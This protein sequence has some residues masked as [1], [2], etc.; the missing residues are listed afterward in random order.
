MQEE[1]SMEDMQIP[2]WTFLRYYI[3]S[4]HWHVLRLKMLIVYDFMSEFFGRIIELEAILF[5]CLSI[6]V[7]PS[8]LL[9]SFPYLT[10]SWFSLCVI[11]DEAAAAEICDFTFFRARWLS[12]I[13]PSQKSKK[14]C[15]LFIGKLQNLTKFVN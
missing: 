10:Q 8:L 7:V 12:S 13:C 4:F 14:I 9:Q 6:S 11:W 5:N 15:R 2:E 1:V 3:N